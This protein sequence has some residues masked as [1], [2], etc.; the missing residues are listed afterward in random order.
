MI[1]F[2]NRDAV[3]TILDTSGEKP[4]YT[5]DTCYHNPSKRRYFATHGTQCRT[6]FIAMNTGQPLTVG[7]VTRSQVCA[8]QK[9]GRRMCEPHSDC[10]ADHPVGEAMSQV[11]SEAAQSF[12]TQLQDTILKIEIVHK[13]LINQ[14]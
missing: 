12:Y 6:P 4:V 11:E 3:G 14:Q 7:M 9:P 1:V 13:Y 8:K 5:C 2:Q 10:M